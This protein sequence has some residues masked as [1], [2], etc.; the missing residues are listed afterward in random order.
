MIRFLNVYFPASIVALLLSELAM[1]ASCYLAATAFVLTVDPIVFLLYDS[2]ILR[3]SIVIG[4][5]L[6]GY[7]FQDM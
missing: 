5:I 4:T 3:I 7:Y 6:I 1:L 2:G